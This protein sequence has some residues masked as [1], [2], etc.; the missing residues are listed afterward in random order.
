MSTPG[1]VISIPPTTFGGETG[2]PGIPGGC[3]CVQRS[4]VIIPR[5][6]AEQLGSPYIPWTEG[7]TADIC[8]QIECPKCPC[9]DNAPDPNCFP[10]CGCPACRGCFWLTVIDE[11]VPNPACVGVTPPCSHE[12]YPNTQ[13]ISPTITIRRF[14]WKACGRPPRPGFGG[15][16][17]EDGMNPTSPTGWDFPETMMMSI[18]DSLSMLS[19]TPLS[20]EP[21]SSRFSINANLEVFINNYDFINMGYQAY[22]GGSALQ[23]QELNE[24]QETLHNQISIA[25]MMLENYLEFTNGINAKSLDP[26]FY[27]APNGPTLSSIYPLIPIGPNTI[28][29]LQSQ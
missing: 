13:P 26:F 11:N 23:A 27:V 16:I 5:H 20:I 22:Y 17:S 12:N 25:N 6:M 28:D 24:L 29:F 8:V 21:Y 4:I 3:L 2:G 7:K 9:V 1:P 19:S 10:T 14:I 18:W 15:T